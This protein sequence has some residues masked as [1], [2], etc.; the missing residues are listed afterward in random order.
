MAKH[1]GIKFA[2]TITLGNGK[3]R[4]A[5]S[6][7]QEYTIQRGSYAAIISI[8]DHVKLLQLMDSI[9]N[10]NHVV[11]IVGKWIFDSNSKKCLLLSKE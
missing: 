8:S 11:T 9:G 6:Q 7:I 4:Q 2:T 10:V 5:D 1:I 3:K